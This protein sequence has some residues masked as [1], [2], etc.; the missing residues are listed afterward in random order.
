MPRIPAIISL[1][2]AVLIGRYSLFECSY[3]QESLLQVSI[4]TCLERDRLQI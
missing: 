2:V 4:V 3:S 1:T